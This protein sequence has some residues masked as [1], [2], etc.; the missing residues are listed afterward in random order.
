MGRCDKVQVGK[1]VTLEGNELIHSSVS[2]ILVGV[3]VAEQKDVCAGQMV[4]ANLAGDGDTVAVL[5][6]RWKVEAD[7]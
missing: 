2:S 7:Q 6:C 4:F 3:F 5:V 1:P